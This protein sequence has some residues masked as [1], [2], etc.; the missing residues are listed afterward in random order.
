V[1]EDGDR[2]VELGKQPDSYDYIHGQYMGLI[3]VRA[4]QVADFRQF[5]AGLDREAIYDGK[6]FDNMYMTSLIQA[7]IDGG[8]DVRAAFTD[9]G[10]L[11]VDTVDDLAHYERMHE[12]GELSRFIRL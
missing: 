8:R 2:V 12:N 11:E 5:Y 9:N 6:D 10:W 1:L 3:K 4:D 7:L